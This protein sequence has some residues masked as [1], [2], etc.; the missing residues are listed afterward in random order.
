[1]LYRAG[2][3]CGSELGTIRATPGL[4]DTAFTRYDPPLPPCPLPPQALECK[5]EQLPPPPP[6]PPPQ[7]PQEQQR[8][9]ERE[10]EG[11]GPAGAAAPPTP[12]VPLGQLY[13]LP[14]LVY[15]SGRSS[16]ARLPDITFPHPA[17]L[18]VFGVV[19]GGALPDPRPLTVLLE[20]HG[21]AAPDAGWPR[22]SAELRFYA[23]S[24]PGGTPR[25][26]VVGCPQ[27]NKAVM[28]MQRVGLRRLDADGTV[29]LVVAPP[30][31]ATPAQVS[32]HPEMGL[33]RA[34]CRRPPNLRP[35]PR[36]QALPSRP[37]APRAPPAG[38][39]S[40]L[41]SRSSPPGCRHP[42]WPSPLQTRLW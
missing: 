1:V 3:G 26:R 41:P 13:E 12:T 15:G 32:W 6:L 29:A 17:V 14:P 20:V 7:Q 31:R 28:G 42:L 22:F 27:L 39:P 24:K 34:C 35:L 8:G 11:A 37:T 5:P 38:P 33:G 19:L 23:D 36:P 30:G 21:E 10:P 16:K 9:P 2:P 4:A 40:T 25:S 18:A